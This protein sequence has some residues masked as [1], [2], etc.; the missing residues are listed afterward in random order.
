MP[1]D[2]RRTQ[3]GARVSGGSTRI[4]GSGLSVGGRGR[5]G[6]WVAAVVLLGLVAA[7]CVPL[8]RPTPP[9]FVPP[10][11]LTIST[12]P[13]LFPSFSTSV[14]DYVSRCST[15]LPV[16]VSVNAPS[17][18]TVS[19][20]GQPPASGQF[21]VPVTRA[22]GQSFPISVQV[23]S[24]PTTT[25]YVRCLPSDFPSWSAQTTGPTQAEWY[26]TE[27][28]ITQTGRSY[29]SIFDTNGV[30]MWWYGTNNPGF[31]FANLL[32]NGNIAWTKANS[33]LE[34]HQLNGTQVPLTPGTAKDDAHDFL[35]LSNG[36]WVFV[37]PYFR[38]GIDL[39]GLCTGSPP[40]QTC[41]PTV[42]QQAAHNP[43]QG[44]L[45]YMI[46]ERKPDAAGTVVWSWDVADHIPVTEMDPQWYAQY[47]TAPSP[48]PPFDVYHWNSIDPTPDGG[49]VLSFRHEDAIYRIDSSGAV[50][51]K[52][53]GSPRADGTSLTI[54]NDP[55]FDGG[56]HL[57]GQH[58]ARLL[59]DGTVTLYDDQTNLDGPARGVRYKIDTSVSPPTATWLQSLTDP[60]IST[61]LCCGSARDVS[62]PDANTGDW[63]MGWG[64]TPN[65][66]GTI[67]EMTPSGTRVFR[68]QF[69]SGTL[70]YRVI[71]VP[72]GKLDRAALR[73]GMDAQYP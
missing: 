22:D 25:Y 55:V 59:S 30:P 1:Y 54:K 8:V 48:P 39:S 15:S 42:A 73:N 61:A 29:V 69:A 17:G 51:W 53:G 5:W 11:P 36:D 38:T 21:T 56:S 60:L 71:P 14:T 44:V 6:G 35:L 50:V 57:G 26:L 66:G 41:G 47:I 23:S 24:Q 32:S 3:R 7:G 37:R 4:D 19:V 16:Q 68:L 63:V 65:P 67:T 45:D 49:Y 10:P 62:V 2:R 12:S 46:E 20:D 34:E 70:L 28:P 9:P 31:G 13:A 52:L 27:G 40:T 18:T 64:G 58:D 33:P 72:F 43:P